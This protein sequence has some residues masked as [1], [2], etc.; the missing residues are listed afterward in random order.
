M[1]QAKFVGSE[2]VRLGAVATFELVVV[3]T[4]G[5]AVL[6]VPIAQ[7]PARGV[8]T[9][10]VELAVLSGRA[11]AAVHSAKD[12]PSSGL[13]PGLILSAVPARGDVRDCLVG[14][15]LDALPAGASVATGSVRRR[16]QLAAV[17]PDL[18]FVELRGNIAT[19]LQKVPAGGAVVVALAAL[20]RLGLLDAV[21]EVLEPDVMLPQVG[22]GALAVRSRADD[23]STID[24]L[25]AIDDLAVHR[26]VDAERAYLARLGGGCDAPVGALATSTG[27]SGPIELEALLGSR[28]RLPVLRKTLTG[29]DPAALGTA[30]ADHLLDAAARL[31]DAR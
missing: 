20:E 11:D 27:P 30:I 10:D 15:S 31:G 19:R 23:V 18:A 26:A 3:S 5:D 16:I 25:S 14:C 29:T 21:S 6:D 1:F 22:Q 2:L 9:T 8:F 17:R 13:P 12:L 4:T 28:D 24:A 7:L